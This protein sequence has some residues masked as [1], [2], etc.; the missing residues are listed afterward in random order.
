MSPLNGVHF[1]QKPCFITLQP[2]HHLGL[3][4]RSLLTSTVLVYSLASADVN[5]PRRVFGSSWSAVSSRPKQPDI[6][7]CWLNEEL[8]L[9]CR[10][11][12]TG[13]HS[14]WKEN[15]FLPEEPEYS[16]TSSLASA[17]DLVLSSQELNALATSLYKKSLWKT[18]LI[19]RDETY[20]L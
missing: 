11:S 10:C 13:W 18:S 7:C 20:F 3:V 8:C 2:I 9:W 5:L 14:C 16:L 12:G 6:P 17:E 4:K 15:G 1:I 19:T